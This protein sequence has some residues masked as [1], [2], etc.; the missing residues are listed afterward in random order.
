MPGL[1]LRGEED[2]PEPAVDDIAHEI[3]ERRDIL[4]QGPRVGL[5]LDDARAALGCPV[6][7]GA[8][9]APVVN[10]DEVV[11]AE[12]ERLEGREQLAGRVRRRGTHVRRQALCLEDGDG[13]GPPADDRRRPERLAELG[14][15]PRRVGHAEESRESHAGRQGDH[16][17][18]SPRGV[19]RL[20]C[21]LRAVGLATS[22]SAGTLTGSPPCRRTSDASSLSRRALE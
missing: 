14:A 15:A 22:R 19:D 18:R 2:G 10:E 7:H 9:P 17:A 6:R 12:V 11:I 20:G 16:R 5:H 8:R 13:L 4:G 1:N 3:L 21:G